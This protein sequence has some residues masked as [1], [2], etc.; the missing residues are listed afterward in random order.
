MSPVPTLRHEK[1]RDR[2]PSTQDN[3]DRLNI[4]K[5]SF[6]FLRHGQTVSNLQGILAGS[7]DVDLTDRGV[8]EAEAAA[9]ILSREKIG[10]I[11]TSPLRR[12]QHTADI[13]ARGRDLKIET[14]DGFRERYWGELEGRAF[15]DSL[16]DPNPP[17]GEPLDLFIDRVVNALRWV[18]RKPTD[19]NIM[20]V[21]HGGVYDAL[22]RALCRNTA[23]VLIGNAVPVI[24]L[25]PSD[26]DGESWSIS[27]LPCENR[28]TQLLSP[29]I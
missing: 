3:D 9:R 20:I 22:C 8:E 14:V 26:G 6:L 24:F 21:A 7:T 4:G 16:G 28:E 5:R 23:P 27:R 19:G 13:I 25:P 2:Q 18:L 15:P 11:V 17:G 29:G 10:R 12:A 1:R